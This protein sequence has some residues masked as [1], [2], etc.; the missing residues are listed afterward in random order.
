[1]KIVPHTEH[2]TTVPKPSFP[3][4]KVSELSNHIL[5]GRPPV[6]ISN[7]LNSASTEASALEARIKNWDRNQF[8]F[9]MQNLRRIFGTHEPV[10]RVM[11]IEACRASRAYCPEVLQR[12]DW[13]MANGAPGSRNDLAT[14]ILLG[15]D[16]VVDWEDI[17]GGMDEIPMDFHTELE[18]RMN[19]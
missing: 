10:K 2:A 19:M 16:A 13:M 15:R 14:E 1:M 12:A 4:E 6:P 3:S 11:E 18:R 8:D 17:Y 7:D 5:A 9:K